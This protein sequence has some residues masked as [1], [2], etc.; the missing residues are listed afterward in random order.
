MIDE[1]FDDDYGRLLLGRGTLDYLDA[2]N[3]ISADLHR[4]IEWAILRNGHR[5]PTLV[6]PRI[7]AADGD[8]SEL[9]RIY[10]GL[11]PRQREVLDLLLKRL[12][13]KRIAQR[14]GISVKTVHAQLATLRDKFQAAS[15]PDLIIL[16]LRALYE[17]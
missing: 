5:A 13:A 6:P 9:G 16:V 12:P 15:S 11:P 17:E 3:L 1:C 7:H 4:H 2:Q 10:E 14:L 8:Q